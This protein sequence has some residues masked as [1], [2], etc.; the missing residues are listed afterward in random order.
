MHI[1]K[2]IIS[3]PLLLLIPGYLIL[4]ASHGGAQPA[5]RLARRGWLQAVVA[6]LVASSWAGLVLL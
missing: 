5:A 4:R 2:L 3:L 6:S 1:M